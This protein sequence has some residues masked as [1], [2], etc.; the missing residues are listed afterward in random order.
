MKE[1]STRKR[2]YASAIRAQGA[3]ATKAAILRSSRALFARRGIDK[4]TIAQIGEKAGVAASTIYA[5]YKS[6]EGILRELMKASL[7]GERYQAAQSLLAGVSDPVHLVELTAHVARAIYE[8]ESAD[9][10]LLRGSS[11]FSPALKKIE[12]EFETIRYEMQ[13][14]RLRLLFKQSKNR[15]GLD[16]EEARRILWMFTSRDVY[17]M[18]VQDAGW[19]PERYQQWLSRTL[20]DAL[21]A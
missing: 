4:V 21:V 14:A 8:S 12:Q 20:L 5:L 9:L 11:S 16:L 10:G 15:K 1:S 19:T 18:L 3:E 7:F 6:K 2:R 17:R 13:E